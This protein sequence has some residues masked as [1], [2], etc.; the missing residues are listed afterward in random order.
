MSQNVVTHSEHGNG[1]MPVGML[2]ARTRRLRRLS[3]MDLAGDAGVS[4]RHLSF[5]ETG[6]ARPSR[7]LVVRLCEALGVPPRETD[8]FL[9]AAGFA[10]QHRET[11]LESPAMAEI[12]AALRLLL[13]RHG[14]PAAAFDGRWD[15]VM[16][17]EAYVPVINLCL[18]AGAD[19]EAGA[20]PI[21]PLTLLPAPR[22]NLLRVL[23]HPNGARQLLAN[24]PEVTRAIL[25]RV[26]RELR[27]SPPA[28]DRM[29]PLEEALAYPGVRRLLAGVP[30]VPAA[31]LLVPVDFRQPDGGITRYITTL[32]TLGTAQDLTLRELRIETYHPVPSA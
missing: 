20:G 30:A 15:I 28:P 6:R 24:W 26:T 9:L 22:P 8:A 27:H 23:C 31:A 7:E 13:E 32:A 3:Q 10:P 4:A 2:L 14:L 21:P 12:L 16:A 11:P 1:S 19:P 17:N 5:V 25:L 18:A 29:P